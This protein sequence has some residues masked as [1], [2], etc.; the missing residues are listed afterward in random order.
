[1]T[2]REIELDL[3]V[4]ISSRHAYLSYARKHLKKEQMTEF[5]MFSDLAERE[6]VRI[7]KLARTYTDIGKLRVDK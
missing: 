7:E 5:E 4:R 2:F 3:K 1:M 6:Q